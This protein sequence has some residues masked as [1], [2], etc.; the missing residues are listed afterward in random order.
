MKTVQNI[1]LCTTILVTPLL[2][3]LLC[4]V[5]LFSNVFLVYSAAQ[6]LQSETYQAT[7]PHGNTPTSMQQY[8]AKETTQQAKRKKENK[9]IKKKK[10]T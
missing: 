4:V 2:F 10:Q 1:P 5:L 6:L 8:T 9:E 7:R 3:L